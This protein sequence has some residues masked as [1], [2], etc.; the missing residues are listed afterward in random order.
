MSRAGS[1]TAA[2][3][4]LLG[5]ALVA[6]ASPASGAET[7]PATRTGVAPSFASL[8]EGHVPPLPD[9][10]PP[11]H[12][13]ARQK[14]AAFVGAPMPPDQLKQLRTAR[15]DIGFSYLFPGEAEAKAFKASHGNRDDKGD[16]CLVD[17]GNAETLKSGR[18]AAD[19]D[20]AA[21]PEPRDWPSNYTGMLSFQFETSPAPGSPRVVV[22]SKRRRVTSS[23]G[24]VHAVHSERFVAGQDG[25]ASLELA[26]AWFDMRTRGARVYGRATLPLTRVF[27]G[28][29]GLEVYAA[30]DG[31]A[32]QLVLHA[33]DHPSG[34]AALAEQLRQRLR[35]MTFTLPDHNGGNGDCGHVRVTLRALPGAGEMAT[36]QSTAFLPPLEGDQG[37]VPE[38]ESEDARGSRLLGLMRQRPFQLSMSATASSADEAPVVSIALG[39][40]GR[41]HTGG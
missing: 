38:G 31:G 2:G 24:D 1:R 18:P 32:V 28:P 4:L 8:P 14:D 21:P 15:Q 35:S 34:D 40:I 17:G 5:A 39:W 13:P 37:A 27:A 25:R 16:A 36:L 19:D 30:R 26:D 6:P 9:A 41:E 10:T 33:P 7:P 11:A 29:N 23:G 3:A 20:D 12:I 22:R